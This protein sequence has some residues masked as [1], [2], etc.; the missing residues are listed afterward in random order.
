MKSSTST[1]SPVNTNFQAPNQ[2]AKHHSG[3]VV[4]QNSGFLHHSV[5][6]S[7]CSAYLCDPPPSAVMIWV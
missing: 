1:T 2:C 4:A 6:V 3:G 7:F 5:S